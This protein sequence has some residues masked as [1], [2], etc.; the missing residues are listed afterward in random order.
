[1]ERNIKNELFFITIIFFA[2][3]IIN[4]SFS[5]VG[6][7][8]FIYPF[9]L[10]FKYKDRIW[11][12]YFC[13]RAGFLGKVI[14]KISFNLKPPK[15][16]FSENAKEFAIYYFIINFVF[17]IFSTVMVALH[18]LYPMNYLR[19]FIIFKIPL[20]FPQILSINLPSYIIHF[21][22]RIYSMMFTSIVIGSILG[23]IFKPRTWCGFCPIYTVTVKKKKR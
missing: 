1:M 5:I 6:L 23:I 14:N 16:L 4:I 15:W 13:P 12:K 20:Q 17:V 10:Y 2:I 19:F 11:C 22:Y 8:C 3:G 9:I 21:G 7:F 18:R